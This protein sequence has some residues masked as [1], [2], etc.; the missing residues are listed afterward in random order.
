MYVLL[1]L[2]IV[3]FFSNV[4]KL[5]TYSPLFF[6]VISFLCSIYFSLCWC[7]ADYSS[8][9][10]LLK[11]HFLLIKRYI[12]IGGVRAY[13]CVQSNLWWQYSTKYIN[14]LAKAGFQSN[15]FTEF[16]SSINIVK[17]SCIITHD[18]LVSFIKI[19]NHGSY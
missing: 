2:N 3:P 10:L 4:D 12:N 17:T 15:H 5:V 14:Y 6:I 7:N 13:P 8:M 9:V 16:C 18:L 11:G 1:Q 19:Y